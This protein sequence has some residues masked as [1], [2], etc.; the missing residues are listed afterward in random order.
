MQTRH[1]KKYQQHLVWRRLGVVVLG[2]LTVAV[3]SATYVNSVRVSQ[4]NSVPVV[5]DK[6]KVMTALPIRLAIPVIQ[7]DAIIAYA[8]LTPDG[9]MDIE[10]DP[11]KVA[12]YN[13]GPRPGEIGSAV[14]AGHYGFLNGKGSVFN[15]LHTLR[16]GDEISVINAQNVTIRFTVRESRS[17]DPT[18]DTTEVFTSSDGKAHLNLITCEGTWVNA[19]NS[20]SDRRVVFTDKT[21]N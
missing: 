8:G 17:Y 21:T 9:A 2:L 6:P 7:V 4:S 19:Q 1:T 10:K 15:G 5:L 13:L 16:T 3:L 11:N 14:I 20:Y 18:A 12:W